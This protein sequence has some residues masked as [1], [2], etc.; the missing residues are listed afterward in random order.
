MVD[1]KETVKLEINKKLAESAEY[2]LLEPI[3][4]SILSAISE[5]KSYVEYKFE[6]E[7]STDGLLKMRAILYNE[8]GFD[9]TNYITN[10]NVII[11]FEKFL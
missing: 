1:F 6:P 8:F 5:S 11:N 10:S 9:I 2:Q 7:L 4:Q 3:K